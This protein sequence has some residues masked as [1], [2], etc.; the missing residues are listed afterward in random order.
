MGNDV[1]T[2]LPSIIWSVL[3]HKQWRDIRQCLSKEQWIAFNIA[4]LFRKR[5]NVCTKYI[6]NTNRYIGNLVCTDLLYILPYCFLFQNVCKKK[7][8]YLTTFPK[9]APLT[10]VYISMKYTQENYSNIHIFTNANFINIF[11]EVHRHPF[12]SW[13]GRHLLIIHNWRLRVML[14]FQKHRTPNLCKTY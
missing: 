2:R 4:V 12:S 5:E 6:S 13:F 9:S 3:K 14:S 1:F 8:M 10:N 11:S 7:N